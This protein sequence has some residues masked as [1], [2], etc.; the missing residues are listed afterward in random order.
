MPKRLPSVL[1]LGML[2]ANLLV[3]LL[4]AAPALATENSS[5]EG[6]EEAADAAPPSA[7]EICSANDVVVEYC[8]EP[9]E[10]PT[11]FGPIVPALLGVGALITLALFLLYM[12]WLPNFA[13]ERKVKA[14]GRR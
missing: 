3:V 11:V 13:Q 7:E 5:A 12:R 14:K 4:P 10:A 6:A 1:L 2:L 8:P 9:Y